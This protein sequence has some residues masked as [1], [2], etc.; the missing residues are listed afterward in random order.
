MQHILDKIRSGQWVVMGVLNVTPDSFSDG[1]NYT[2]VEYAVKQALMMQQQGAEIIDIGGESTRPG[3]EKVSQDEE[4]DRVIPVIEKIRELSNVVISIDTSKPQVMQAAIDAGADMVNDVN[5][6]HAEG[7]I[8]VCVKHE[9]PVCLMHKQGDSQTMQENPVYDEI[10]REIKQYLMARANVCIQAGIS[11]KN[12]LIDP[13]FGFGK[14]LENNLSLLKEM[15]LFSEL[16]YP[17]LV[18]VSRKS[19]FGMLLDRDVE[20]RLAAS[21]AAVVIAYQKGARFFRVHD[22]SETCDALKLCAAVE[23]NEN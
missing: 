12:I 20:N 15:P 2:Q 6:L 16:A 11:S 22:V 7:A 4:L 18:G 10:V 13:G 17:V 5:A 9:I 19:M 3:A 14:T 21:V 8:E 23:N 1:G